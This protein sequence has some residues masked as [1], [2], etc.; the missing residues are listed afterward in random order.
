MQGKL[1]VIPIS[2][3]KIITGIRVR[4]T[5]SVFFLPAKDNQLPAFLIACG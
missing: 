4:L 3:F 1:P 5:A 2:Y